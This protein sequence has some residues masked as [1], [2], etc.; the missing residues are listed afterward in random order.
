M[1]LAPERPVALVFQSGLHSLVLFVLI[2]GNLRHLV[3]EIITRATCGAIV[4]V[5]ASLP[6]PLRPHHAEPVTFS[7][8]NQHYSDL[9]RWCSSLAFPS[10]VLI[11]GNLWHL[12]H[13][14]GTRATCGASVSG[15]A[16]LPC[17]LRP[18]HGEPVTFSSWN[19]HQSDLR[20]WCSSVAFPSLVPFVLI[21]GNLW[22]LVYEIGTRATCGA[23]VPVRASLPLSSSSSSWG[24]C[25]IKFMKLALEHPAA[26]VYQSGLHS[27]VL[28]I[29]IMGNLWHLVHEIATRA[30]CGASVPVR[31]SLP[32]PL[33]PHHGEPATFSSWNYH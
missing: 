27:L 1:K 5:R 30:T 24:T 7:S 33:R 12:V 15:R 25:D 19:W 8:R 31:A 20:R 2:M 22:H 17:P 18:H 29:L 14:I 16:S 23:S 28:F 32:C 13:E 6:C 3:H 9:R 21:M 4:P 11:M 26:L 10:L